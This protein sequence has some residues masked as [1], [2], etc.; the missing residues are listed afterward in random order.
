MHCRVI[1]CAATLLARLTLCVD[2]L[3][4]VDTPLLSSIS[5]TNVILS[6]SSDRNRHCSLAGRGWFLPKD[7]NL[8]WC[9]DIVPPML[10]FHSKLST[11]NT[12]PHVMRISRIARNPMARRM[13]IQRPICTQRGALRWRSWEV[14]ACISTSFS[15]R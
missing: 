4:L 7:M 11:I 9:V 8:I 15:D 5:Q 3:Q 14:W 6:F 1:A 13:M 2:Y 12:N 10:Y